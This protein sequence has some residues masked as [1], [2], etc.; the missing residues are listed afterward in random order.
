MQRNVEL[1]AFSEKAEQTEKRDD[2][3]GK[4]DHWEDQAEK[5]CVPHRAHRLEYLVTREWHY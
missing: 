5:C 3:M 2:S 1:Q 4:T